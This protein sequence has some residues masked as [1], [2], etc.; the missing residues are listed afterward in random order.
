M[1]TEIELLLARVIAGDKPFEYGDEGGYFVY[2]HWKEE[3]ALWYGSFLIGVFLLPIPLLTAWIGEQIGGGRGYMVG[4]YLGF[5]PIAFAVAGIW[6]HTM[7][8]VALRLYWVVTVHSL[9]GPNPFPQPPPPPHRIRWL[10]ASTSRDA[11]FQVVCGIGTVL[12]LLS[13]HP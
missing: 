5:G 6:L 8:A 11:V 2:Y 1:L 9:S 10:M 7:R 4:L 3:F 12:V 13:L